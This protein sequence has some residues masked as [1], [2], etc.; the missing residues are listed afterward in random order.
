M[1]KYD[2]D[3]PN[4]IF[5]MSHWQSSNVCLYHS[6]HKQNL[7]NGWQKVADLQWN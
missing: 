1:F 4:T 3:F 2:R 5:A 6:L 7:E